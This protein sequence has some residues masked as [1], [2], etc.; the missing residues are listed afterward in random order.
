MAKTVLFKRIPILSDLPRTE[1]DYLA[2]T[3]RI[4]TLKAGEVLF[5]EEEMGECLFIVLEGELEVLM[6]LGKP[7]QKKMGNL[8]VR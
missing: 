5:H 1:L 3:L 7:D 2:S 6:G 8:S 4:V